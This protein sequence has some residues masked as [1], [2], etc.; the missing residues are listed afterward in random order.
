MD[1]TSSWTLVQYKYERHEAALSVWSSYIK[2]EEM[3][4]AGTTVNRLSS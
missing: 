1:L 2:P 4:E 3:R